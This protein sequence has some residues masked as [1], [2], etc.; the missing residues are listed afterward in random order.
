M[1]GT[2]LQLW[3]MRFSAR[4]LRITRSFLEVIM[5]IYGKEFYYPDG[6]D[7]YLEQ[8]KEL[9]E[10]LQRGL[11]YF[12]EE[13]LCVISPSYVLDNLIEKMKNYVNY[14]SIVSGCEHNVFL[15]N[16]RP[17]QKMRKITQSFIDF[18]Y[19]ARDEQ[20]AIRDQ[21]LQSLRKVADSRVTGLNF[22]IISNSII[23]HFVYSEMNDAKKKKQAQ[24]ADKW[25]SRE[26][27]NI[28]SQNSDALDDR[29][30]DYK[31]NVYIP[32]LR[33]A[34]EEF[35]IETFDKCIKILD[36]T[37]RIDLAEI[38]STD[39]DMDASNSY[40]NS[41][42][43]ITEE[44]IYKALSLCPYNP[45]VYKVAYQNKLF[46]NE[47]FTLSFHFGLNIFDCVEIN[48]A[49]IEKINS[50]LSDG[51]FPQLYLIPM[52]ENTEIDINE[53]IISMFNNL[54]MKDK[55]FIK[56]GIIKHI[57]LEKKKDNSLS[58]HLTPDIIYFIN[59]IKILLTLDKEIYQEIIDKAFSKEIDGVCQKF[60]ALLRISNNPESLSA[61]AKTKRAIIITNSDISL[62]LKYY[63]IFASAKM[64]KIVALIGGAEIEKI[65][66]YLASLNEKI[67]ME[68]EK[69][70]QAERERKAREEQLARE[71]REQEEKRRREIEEKKRLLREEIQALNEELENLGFSFFG[72]KAK[73]KAEIKSLLIEKTQELNN[74]K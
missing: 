35:Y 62:F 67:S 38:N 10:F 69:H 55:E 39:Y 66:E 12:D 18:R 40:L 73:R 26:S 22:G 53:T 51:R 11:E 42:Y 7:K 56:K 34:F 45:N 48:Y 17:L 31:E 59:K 2:V 8:V 3:V 19:Q 52:I 1:I 71:R 43:T 50:V 47:L 49:E 15:E 65:N 44:V 33:Q 30:Y 27:S 37:E 61:Y 68:Y 41:A 6:L 29:V 13:T 64:K 16:S 14:V 20:R 58:S 36:R 57:E 72:K 21:Q 60:D 46:S 70:Q 5:I 9:K 32:I 25:Y 54:P 24:E 4:Y 23:S 63:E 28:Y 74:L